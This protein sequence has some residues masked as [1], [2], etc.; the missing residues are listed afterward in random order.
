MT[1]ENNLISL[2]DR[3]PEERKE[4]SEKGWKKSKEVREERKMFRALFEEALKTNVGK[5]KEGNPID[6]KTMI[7][8]Q[9]VKK[10]TKGDLQAYREIAKQLGEYEVDY[11]N[12]DTN[13][14]I[15]KALSGLMSNADE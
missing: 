15:F 6:A 11:S 8:L 14:A 9:M 3:P 13:K 2:A 5:D 10:A 12:D 7:V 1:N 4:I